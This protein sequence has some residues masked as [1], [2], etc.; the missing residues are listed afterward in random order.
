MS[1]RRRLL[2]PVDARVPETGISSGILEKEATNITGKQD[3]EVRKIFLK[4]GLEKDTNGSAYIEAGDHVI[5]ASVFGPKPIRGTFSDRGSLSVECKFFPYVAQPGEMKYNSKPVN[6]NSNARTAL[7]M[8]EH[9]LSNYLESTLLPSI[10]LERYPKSS[11]E[12]FVT[13]LSTSPADDE[14]RSLLNLASWIVVC[15]SLALVDSQIELK[16]IVSSGHAR[17]NH[18]TGKMVLDPSFESRDGDEFTECLIS[19]MDQKN[20]EIVGLWMDGERHG[21]EE[22]SISLLVESALRI[23]KLVRSNVNSYLMQIL[24]TE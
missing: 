7:T 18:S 22:E 24:N 5:Q 23:S 9:K 17:F 16:D 15:A 8:V 3:D 12:V 19:S 1:D 20:N 2:G 10:I 13:I 4:T 6:S 11:I 21:L 14:G